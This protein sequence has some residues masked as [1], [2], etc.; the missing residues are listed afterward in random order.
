MTTFSVFGRII[1][2]SNAMSEFA[3]FSKDEEET[4]LPVPLYESLLG[5]A[6]EVSSTDYYDA[7]L[8]RN[9]ALLTPRFARRT[10]ACR[11]PFSTAVTSGAPLRRAK[12]SR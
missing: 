3:I 8:V 1:L 10:R 5:K 4:M 6:K 2:H 9:I 11:S 7:V 12:T